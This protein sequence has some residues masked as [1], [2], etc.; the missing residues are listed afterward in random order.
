MTVSSAYV[1]AALLLHYANQGI[2]VDNLKKV[3]EAAGIPPD[4]S[5]IKALA[6]AISEV[7]VEEALK[8]APVGFAPQAPTAPATPAEAKKEEKKE[9]EKE[10][11]KEDEALAGLGALFG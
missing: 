10:E 2:N 3:L 6:A 7:N 8:A 11:K 5:R 1:H 4:E 9:K